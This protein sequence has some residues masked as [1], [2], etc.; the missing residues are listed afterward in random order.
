MHPDVE[1][2]DKPLDRPPPRYLTPSPATFKN[3]LCCPWAKTAIMRDTETYEPIL[4]PITCKRWGCSYCAPRKIKKLAF[5][6]SHAEPNRW[7]RLGVKPENYPGP[8]EA[9]Q[10]TSPKLPELCKV[11]REKTGE[12]EYL[13]VCELHKSGFPHYH[14][15]LRSAFIPQKLLSDTWG[16]MTGARVVWIAKIDQTFSSFRYLTKYLTKL[17]RIEWTD[18]HVS[19]SRNFFRPEDTEK[20]AHPSRDLIEKSEDHPWKFLADHYGDERVALEAAGYWT[21]PSKPGRK[22]SD[23]PLSAFGLRTQEDLLAP[24]DELPAFRQSQLPGCESANAAT[25]E[26]QSF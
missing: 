8:K 5:L 1:L 18:R 7:I 13:R 9:W 21:L 3:Y 11:L 25:W 24:A 19:Y 26:D 12:C 16:S 23:L 6:T 2:A 14:A 4:V 22:I 10:D 15:L 17:H 20:L